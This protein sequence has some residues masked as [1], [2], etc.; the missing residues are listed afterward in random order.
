VCADETHLGAEQRARNEAWS[1]V[2]GNDNWQ[3]K[4]K[5]RFKARFQRRSYPVGWA[6]ASPAA[7]ERALDTLESLFVTHCITHTSERAMEETLQH[8]VRQLSGSISTVDKEAA[9]LLPQNYKALLTLLT[10]KGLLQYDEEVEIPA[11]SGCYLW[12]RKQYSACSSCPRC[13]RARTRDNVKK[14]IWRGLIPYARWVYRLKCI[15]EQFTHW[16]DRLR[17][18]I[19]GA[20]TDVF[21]GSQYKKKILSDLRFA[22]DSRHLVGIVFT[23]PFQVRLS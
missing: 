13:G 4:A 2:P 8:N 9:T 19:P 22:T 6:T 17:P 1:R 14:V 16:R 23:D 15:S 5:A 3:Q 12:F 21:D 20:L 10:D 7:A 11:C 18:C